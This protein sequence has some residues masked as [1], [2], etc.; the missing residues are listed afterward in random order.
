M[1][2]R[3]LGHVRDLANSQ[4]ALWVTTSDYVSNQFVQNVGCF[5]KKCHLIKVSNE[6]F[7]P[8]AIKSCA[9]AQELKSLHGMG[10]NL[11]NNSHITV[12]DIL[13]LD[14]IY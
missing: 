9:I 8:W 14:N 1:S 10:M 13:K 3:K 6:E 5:K 7:I 12:Q 4:G 2:R 11:L